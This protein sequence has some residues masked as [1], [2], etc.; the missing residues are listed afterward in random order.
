M[1]QTAILLVLNA[2]ITF[3]RMQKARKTLGNVKSKR[4][5]HLNTHCDSFSSPRKEIYE[6][7]I[8]FQVQEFIMVSHINKS[9]NL[10]WALPKY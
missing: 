8:S 6:A 5:F 3:Y 4:M 1:T 7:D 9:E 2:S 10:R